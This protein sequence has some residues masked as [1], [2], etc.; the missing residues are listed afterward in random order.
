M[1]K[2]SCCLVLNEGSSIYFEPDGSEHCQTEIPGGGIVVTGKLQL[3]RRFPQ[4]ED[5]ARRQGELD[6]FIKARRQTGYAMG[7]LKKGGRQASAEELVR[8]AGKQPGGIPVGLTRCGTC[9]QWRGECLDPNPDLPLRVVTV[10]CRCQNDTLCASC[11]KPLRE[12]RVNG[13][14]YSERDGHVWHLPGFCAFEHECPKKEQPRSAPIPRPAPRRQKRQPRGRRIYV[15]STE[16]W[17]SM[18]TWHVDY[19]IQQCGSQWM[20]HYKGEEN[21]RFDDGPTDAKGIVEAFEEHGYDIEEFLGQLRD[22]DEAAVKEL[23]KEM[24]ALLAKPADQTGEKAR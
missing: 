6:A 22:V 3:V 5:S 15:G 20:V 24:T 11:G 23:A 1:N 21:A 13:N 9:G 18:A 14:S 17:G 2:F 19:W 7:D 16:V 8:L 4:T 10:H 12:E